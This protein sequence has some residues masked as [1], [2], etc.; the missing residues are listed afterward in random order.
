MAAARLPSWLTAKTRPYIV[1][2]RSAGYQ[3]ASSTT[4]LMKLA[5]QPKPSRNRPAISPPAVSA[6]AVASAPSTAKA[7]TPSTV[8]RG[9][10]RSKLMPTGICATP[11]AR[12]NMPP[13]SPSVRGESPRSSISSG[14]ITAIDER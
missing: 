8:L 9:P 6:E 2:I 12:K 14:A 4:A 11:S 5:P 3:R 1:A 7:L 10:M 13:A